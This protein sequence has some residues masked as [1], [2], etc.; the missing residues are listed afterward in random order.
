MLVGD[1]DLRVAKGQQKQLCHRCYQ[2]VQQDPAGGAPY[3]DRNMDTATLP[4]KACKGGIR[5]TI[6]FPT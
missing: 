5:T 2:N 3:A 4:L 6:T 1:P